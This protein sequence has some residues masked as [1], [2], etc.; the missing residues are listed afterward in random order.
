MAP[1]EGSLGEWNAVGI[2]PTLEAP[3]TPKAEGT[4]PNRQTTGIHGAGG[5]RNGTSENRELY[6][7]TAREAKERGRGVQG[8]RGRAGRDRPLGRKDPEE[9][10][11]P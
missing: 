2:E 9:G 4:P 6:A 7:S 1:S 3:P 11:K 5:R 8:E 10:G